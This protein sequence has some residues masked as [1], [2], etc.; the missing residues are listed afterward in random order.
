MM[1]A[2]NDTRMHKSVLLNETIDFLN[3]QPNGFY[4]DGTLGLGGHA[5]AILARLNNDG[6]LLGLDVDSQNLEKARERL[7]P[8]GQRVHLK[9]KNFRDVGFALDELAW[10]EVDGMLFDLGVASPQIDVAERGLS[11]QSEGP[12]DMRLDQSGKETALTLLHKMDERALESVLHEFGEERFARKLSRSILAAVAAGAVKT[13]KDLA[14]V[15][16]RAIGRHGKTHPATRVF[17]ALRATVNDE[18]GALRS[19]LAVAPA[20]LKKGGR[21][22]II[23]FHSLEDRMVKETFRSL[24]NENSSPKQFSLLTKKPVVPS[25]AEQSENPRSRSAKLRVIE[26]TA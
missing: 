14:A 4:V 19:M 2:R 21:L 16:E 6:R 25:D 10:P 8:F 1:L 3:I 12:L 18:L 13:T 9:Q 26:R 24:T 15:C 23:S 20:R 22:A 11:F 5:E 7:K 17:L